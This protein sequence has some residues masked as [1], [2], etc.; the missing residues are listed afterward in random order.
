MCNY[1]NRF[2]HSLSFAWRS[3]FRVSRGCVPTVQDGSA[4]SPSGNSIERGSSQVPRTAAVEES[5]RK[6]PGEW[7]QTSA[8][9]RARL[10]VHGIQDYPRNEADSIISIRAYCRT[11]PLCTALKPA[12]RATHGRRYKMGNKAKQK[13]C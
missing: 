3:S 13:T 1:V 9:R 7:R 10:L 6:P 2:F 12:T 5:K 4:K 11:R 8:G